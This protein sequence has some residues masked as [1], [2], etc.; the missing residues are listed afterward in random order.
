MLAS[1]LIFLSVVLGVLKLA[2]L[3]VVSW[4]VVLVPIYALLVCLFIFVLLFITIAVIAT[5]NG[6]KANWKIGS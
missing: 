5:W 6:E 3:I 1:L 4:H 2:G